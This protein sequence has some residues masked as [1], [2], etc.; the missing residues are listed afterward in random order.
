MCGLMYF[1]NLLMSRFRYICYFFFKVIRPFSFKFLWLISGQDKGETTDQCRPEY[2]TWFSSPRFIYLFIFK[3]CLAFDFCWFCVAIRFF[4]PATM[5]NDLP[6]RRI[7]Y[8]RFYPL[9]FLSLLL[10]KGTT[11]TIFITSLVWRGPWL[12]IEPGNSHT[13]SQHSTTRL[14]K[15]QYFNDFVSNCKSNP[16]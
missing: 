10:N 2:C 1:M 9:H 11:G 16:L 14:S 3:F 7:F 5:A 6:L 8:P 15:R 12:G 4:I 13:G